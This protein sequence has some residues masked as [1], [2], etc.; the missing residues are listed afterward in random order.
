MRI[1]V[2]PPNPSAGRLSESGAGI[3][4][5]LPAVSSAGR[6]SFA[7]ATRRSVSVRSY[8]DPIAAD[9]PGGWGGWG[10]G[11]PDR[12]VWPTARLSVAGTPGPTYDDGCPK[13]HPPRPPSPRCS[14]SDRR[15]EWRG[16]RARP[17]E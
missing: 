1:D 14:R 13:A 15:L 17:E 16:S 12:T 9:P 5:S 2:S 10:L 7:G 3:L 11:K 6:T 8:G 4:A